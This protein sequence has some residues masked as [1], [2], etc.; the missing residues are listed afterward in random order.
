MEIVPDA[1]GL[2]SVQVIGSRP[3][4]SLAS[5]AKACV[6]EVELPGC[7]G[8][9]ALVDYPHRDRGPVGGADQYV[10]PR[11]P[12]PTRSRC[13]SSPRSSGHVGRAVEAGTVTVTC[14]VGGRDAGV[15]DGGL[16]PSRQGSRDFPADVGRGVLGA[17][18]GVRGAAGVLLAAEGVGVRGEGGGLVTGGRVGAVVVSAVASGE[19]ESRGTLDLTAVADEPEVRRGA[20]PLLVRNTA[21]RQTATPT[22]SR[23]TGIPTA[24]P[25]SFGTCSAP[26]FVVL[27]PIRPVDRVDVHPQL[28]PKAKRLPPSRRDQR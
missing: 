9:R 28:P 18:R 15:A 2:S 6:A 5:L 21:T 16:D 26:C 19:P 11:R 20:S 12:W 3:T 13:G 8:Q 14:L 1:A 17:T 27:M 24:N 4:E 7:A 23:A 25:C 22:A 10:A